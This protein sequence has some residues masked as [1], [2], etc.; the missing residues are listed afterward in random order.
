MTTATPIKVEAIA[1]GFYNTRIRRPGDRFL[2]KSEKDLGSWMKRLDR[3]EAEAE[4]AAEAEV[5]TEVDSIGDPDLPPEPP[6]KPRGLIKPEADTLSSKLTE[7]PQTAGEF[8]AG[9]KGQKGGNK[10]DGL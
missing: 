9:K 7:Q 2:I 8:Y 3:P 4:A 1:R 6:G 10:S 5:A